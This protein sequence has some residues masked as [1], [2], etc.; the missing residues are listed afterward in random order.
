MTSDIRKKISM[1]CD[2]IEENIIEAKNAKTIYEVPELFRK[3]NLDKI[4]LNHF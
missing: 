1:S 4:I 3:Q 2:I